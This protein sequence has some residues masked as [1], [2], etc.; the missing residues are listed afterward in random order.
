MIINGLTGCYI[1]FDTK[2]WNIKLDTL[3]FNPKQIMKIRQSKTLN[4][5]VFTVVKNC[6][7]LIDGIFIVLFL[8]YKLPD[9]DK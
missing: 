5:S 2:N 7:Y 1:V 3:P 9:V 6:K 4:H 8:S